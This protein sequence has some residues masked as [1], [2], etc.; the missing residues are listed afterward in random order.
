ME[1]ILKLEKLLKSSRSK[2]MDAKRGSETLD[3]LDLV[4]QL[5]HQPIRK[6]MPSRQNGKT[7]LPKTFGMKIFPADINPT[8]FREGSGF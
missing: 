3:L 6:M 8:N 2:V 1:E 7:N 4:V 5:V